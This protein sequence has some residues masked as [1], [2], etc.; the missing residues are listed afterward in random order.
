MTTKGLRHVQ[1]RENAVRESVQSGFAT[2]KHINGKSNLSDIFTKEDRDTTHYLTVRG[3]LMSLP[4]SEAL[5][6]EFV[7]RITASNHDCDTQNSDPH[8]IT[9]VRVTSK[10]GCRLSC[11][12]RGI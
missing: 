5:S 11:V 10:G 1:M 3:Q 9:N 7:R 12:R 8:E 2:I 4:P 6:S